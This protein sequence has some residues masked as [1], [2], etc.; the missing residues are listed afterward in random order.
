MK[1]NYLPFIFILLISCNNDKLELEIKDLKTEN[2]ELKEDS[3]KKI[4]SFAIYTAIQKKTNIK[5]IDTFLDS[6]KMKDKNQYK[7]LL[8]RVDERTFNWGSDT[9]DDE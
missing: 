3:K 5:K 8:K 7:L 6:L 9:S 4:D 2:K 1:K